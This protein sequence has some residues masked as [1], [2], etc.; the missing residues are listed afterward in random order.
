MA[1]FALAGLGAVAAVV[2][3]LASP[4]HAE[5]HTAADLAV[6]PALI[7]PCPA[8]EPGLPA[9][10]QPDA[11]LDELVQAGRHWRLATERGAI[12]VWTP[13]GYD[14]ATAATVVFVHGY[15]IDADEAWT[16]YRLA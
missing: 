10:R 5:V 16:S 14:A 1:R 2:T 8:A 7:A 9:P 4:A 12:H 6:A 13:A 3:Q 15:W 11:A